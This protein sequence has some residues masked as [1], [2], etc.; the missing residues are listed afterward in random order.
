MFEDRK[1]S[2]EFLKGKTKEELQHILFKYGARDQRLTSYRTLKFY[3][4]VNMVREKLTDLTLEEIL[5]GGKN[6]T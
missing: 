4:D 3:L 6:D 2:E 5:L 1:K